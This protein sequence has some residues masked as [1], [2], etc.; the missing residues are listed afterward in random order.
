[1]FKFLQEIEPKLYQR[2]LTVERN[3]KAGSNSFYDS[4]LDLQEQFVKIVALD[5]GIE[6]GV[7]D[8]VG[9]LLR[10]AT[11][12]TYFFETLGV[13]EYTYNKMQ[14]YRLSLRRWID[15]TKDRR[16]FGLAL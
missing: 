7:R 5:C 8:S 16:L 12:K 15:C 4:Y 11:L 14:D 1:M 13:E 6:F 2:Y 9:Q 10:N 3:V